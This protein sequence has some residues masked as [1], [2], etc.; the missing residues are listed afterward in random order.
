MNDHS[1]NGR[2]HA[3]AARAVY[4]LWQVGSHVL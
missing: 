2:E 1:R 4:I 3:V